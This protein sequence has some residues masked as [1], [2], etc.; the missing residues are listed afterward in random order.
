MNFTLIQDQFLLS[1]IGS[2]VKRIY[3]SDDHRLVIMV[4]LYDGKYSKLS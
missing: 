4:E 1:Q 3:Q 2:K